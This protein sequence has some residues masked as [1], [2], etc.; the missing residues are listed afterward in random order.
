M[1][2]DFNL[3]KQRTLS[4]YDTLD[5]QTKD[6]LLYQTLEQMEN[7]FDQRLAIVDIINEKYEEWLRSGI[8]KFDEMKVKEKL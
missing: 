2:N 8:I 4:N 7:E 5:G 3:L 6:G 1:A